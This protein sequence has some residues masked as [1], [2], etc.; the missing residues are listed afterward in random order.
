[1]QSQ[2]ANQKKTHYKDNTP[3]PWEMQKNNVTLFT[4]HENT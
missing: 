3:D 4:I 2:Q 1:M